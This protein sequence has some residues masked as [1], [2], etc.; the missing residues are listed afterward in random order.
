MLA[1]IYHEVYNALY[2]NFYILEN[3]FTKIF[4]PYCAGCN[5][6]LFFTH[7]TFVLMGKSKK[8]KS[9]YKRFNCYFCNNDCF[10][11]WKLLTC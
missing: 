2:T 3:N 1:N 7:S 9:L 4:P 8:Y 10:E 11:Y 5:K 6:Y